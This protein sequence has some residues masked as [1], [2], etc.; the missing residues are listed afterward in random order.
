MKKRIARLLT[1]M[2]VLQ[3]AACI[4]EEYLSKAEKR[5][6]DLRAYDDPVSEPGYAEELLYTPAYEGDSTENA[7]RIYYEIDLDGQD[8]ETFMQ[9]DLFA[10]MLNS[11]SSVFHENLTAAGLT[12][13]AFAEILLDNEK[14]VFCFGMISANPED[15]P[16]FKAAVDSTLADVAVYYSAASELER[17]SLHRV[18]FDSSAVPQEDLHYITLY[19]LLLTELEAGNYSKAQK[20]HLMAQYLYRFNVDTLYP[21][22]GENQYPMLRIEWNC[23]A[24]DY[25]TSLQLLLE[26]MGGLKLDDRDELIRVLDKNLP[27]LDWSRGDPYD[28]CDLIATAGVS[29]NYQYMDYLMGQRF[30][31]FARELRAQLDTDPDAMETIAAK[32]QSVQ[33]LILHKDRMAVMNVAPREEL[34]EIS[35]ISRQVLGELPSL[36][37]V[38]ADYRLPEYPGRTGVIVEGANYNTFSVSDTALADGLSGTFFPFV[39]ALNDRYI[40]P[41]LRFQGLAYGAAMGY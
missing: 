4:H 7:S 36:Q 9:Y 40:V 30:Y 21:E 32:L 26:I 41:R 27:S 34:A 12:A 19:S 38:Q 2:A 6:T 13:P 5:G 29:R 35:S 15:A 25:G 17:I 1:L 8:W 16:G 39:M 23:M 33:E 28:L 20:D 24:Q 14:T 10:S 22:A 18:H 37:P 31:E 11:D 3:L